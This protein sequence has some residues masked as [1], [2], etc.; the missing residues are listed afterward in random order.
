M[1]R[2]LNCRATDF[3]NITSR[4]ELKQAIASS[5]GRT[6]MAET[7]ATAAPLYPDVTNAELLATFGVD[8]IILKGFDSMNPSIAGLKLEDVH[9]G[10]EEPNNIVTALKRITGRGIGINLEVVGSDDE[11]DGHGGRVSEETVKRVKELGADFIC[12][13]GYAK[14]EV[15]TE[16]VLKAIELAK[17]HFGGLIMVA[18]FNSAGVTQHKDV[19]LEFVKAGADIIVLPA[20]GSVPGITED[21][22]YD[23]IEEVKALGALT[24]TTISTSQEGSDKDTIRQ[25]ALSSKRAGT[26]IHSLGDAGIAG[27]CEPENVM[28]ISMTIRGKR[29]TYVRMASSIVR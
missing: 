6:L 18:K 13:T 20:P 25:M 24:M 29:H 27:M 19:Y 9:F 5:E 12:L 26:D 1:K 14:P 7:A 22:L 2:V 28:T 3:F 10:N 15:T 16:R 17:E 23:V 11:A 4:E 8:F 21:R